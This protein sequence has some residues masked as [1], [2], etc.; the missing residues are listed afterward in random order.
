MFDGILDA[1]ERLAG[2]ADEAHAI[3]NNCHDDKAVRNARELAT[4][5]GASPPPSQPP[6]QPALL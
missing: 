2:E 3:M 6:S 1:T 5:L 4:L